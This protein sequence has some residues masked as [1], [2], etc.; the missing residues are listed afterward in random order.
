MTRYEATT[1]DLTLGDGRTLRVHD[2]GT[3]S[4]PV[5]WHHG[6]PQTGALLEPLLDAAATRDIRFISYG[7]PSY[8]GSSSNRGRSIGSA[9]HDVAQAM[10]ALGIDRFATIGHSG[11]AV[12]A[13]AVAALLGERV[14]ALVAISPLAPY[15]GATD[16]F[17]G[18]SWFEGMAGGGAAL[19][20]ALL[21]REAY[22]QFE[23]T[24]DFDASSFNALDYAALDGAWSA[25][26]DDVGVASKAGPEGITDDDLALVSPWGF[27]PSSIA[28][29]TLIVHGGDDRIAPAAHARWLRDQV[30]GSQLWL[31]PDDGHVSVLERLP[32]ALDWLL[33]AQP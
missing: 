4:I 19:R 1:H 24:A 21:G 20:A 15:N 8:G 17:E 30:A 16:W 22:E 5:L 32:E 14:T 28:S 33:V 18:S 29:P 31:Q 26:G 7:R 13:L 2:S 10:D 6:S 12:H 25:M 23:A 11:G 27:E 9:A 3:G